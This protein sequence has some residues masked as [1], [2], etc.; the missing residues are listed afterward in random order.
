MRFL[1]F[2]APWAY[3]RKVFVLLRSTL[4]E[5]EANVRYRLT[6]VAEQWRV[7]CH[8]VV[9]HDPKDQEFGDVIH[10]GA[11]RGRWSMDVLLSR[12]GNS[13]RQGFYKRVGVGLLTNACK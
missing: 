11:H 6:D 1:R 13:V 12:D 3:G 8:V 4:T 7:R 9:I 2:Q 10:G 5:R